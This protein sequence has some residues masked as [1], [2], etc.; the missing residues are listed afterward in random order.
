MK[1]QRLD[2]FRVAIDGLIESLD[3]TIRLSR[4][5]D[6]D[7]RPPELVAAAAKLVDRLGAA[8][9]LAATKYQGTLNDIG[10]VDAMCAILKQLDGIYLSYRKQVGSAERGSKARDEA[11]TALETALATTSTTVAAANW[12]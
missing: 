7:P 4:C 10:K 8:D 5:A 12:R 9:R 1:D 3:A 11:I 6:A 2:V